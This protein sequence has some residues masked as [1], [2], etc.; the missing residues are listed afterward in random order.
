MHIDR[1]IEK[2]TKRGPCPIEVDLRQ[3]GWD[4]LLPVRIAILSYVDRSYDPDDS[5]DFIHH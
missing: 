2:E 4:I 1:K 5:D 3:I